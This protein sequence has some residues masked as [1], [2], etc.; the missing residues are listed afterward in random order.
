MSP[1]LRAT[2]CSRMD[3]QFQAVSPSNIVSVLPN[4]AADAINNVVAKLDDIGIE[5]VDDL[6]HV[7]QQDLVPLLKPIQAR[8]I[9]DAWSK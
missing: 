7:E 3:S 6:Q 9:M 1:N 5:I 4:L 2:H 8:K